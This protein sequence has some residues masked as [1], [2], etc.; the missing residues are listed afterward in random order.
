MEHQE[1]ASLTGVIFLPKFLVRINHEDDK[2][3]P[4]RSE[5]PVKV[6]QRKALAMNPH[7]YTHYI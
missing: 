2:K 6:V 3:C 1:T 4:A 5:K 7:L